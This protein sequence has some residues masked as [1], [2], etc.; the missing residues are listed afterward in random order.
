MISFALMKINK[1]KL[2]CLTLTLQQSFQI[3][4][5]V[6]GKSA[7]LLMDLFLFARHKE[8]WVLAVVCF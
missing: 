2:F 6:K 7:L 5:V 3:F 1:F 4:T 8:E